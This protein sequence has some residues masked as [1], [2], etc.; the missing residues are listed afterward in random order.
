MEPHPCS[1]D[2]IFIFRV[3]WSRLDPR[4]SPLSSLGVVTDALLSQETLPGGPGNPVSK[5]TGEFAG[6]QF[7]IVEICSYSHLP[8]KKFKQAQ[9]SLN[10]TVR[11][12]RTNNGTEF[13]NQTLLNYTKDIRI[14]HNTSTARTPQQNGVVERRN[15][16]LIATKLKYLHVFGALCYPTNDF[17]D[18]GKLQPKAD[19]GIFI[20]YSPS[21]MAY[22]IY[23][24]R[25]RQIMETM[26]V[27]FDEL[28]QMAF[29]QH[30]LGPNLHGLTSGH[31]SS[32]LVLNQATS[33][34]A[35]PSIKNDWDLASS[36]STSIDNDAP[37]PSTSPNNETSSLLINSTNVETNEEVAEFDSDTFTNLFAPLDT[38]LP[39]S[40]SRI[41]D[42]SN[43]HTFQQPPIIDDPSTIHQNLLLQ[44]VNFLPMLYGVI[45]IRS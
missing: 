37:S 28:T 4:M 11:Y 17:E 45:S 23:N 1:C 12:L 29:E 2:R 35:K 3:C 20:S 7:L 16:T 42:T 38:S 32:G 14:T 9:V 39:E 27:Q 36:S 13:L 21:K 31:I 22:R 43:M 33:T 25:N 24:K 15:R 34:S 26:N 5:N 8:V 6:Y 44:V 10:A 41:F 18:L 30:G 40:S 19:I